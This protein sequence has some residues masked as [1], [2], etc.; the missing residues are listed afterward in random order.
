MKVHEWSSSFYD[1]DEVEK[2]QLIINYIVEV[3]Q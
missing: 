1:I 2:C 3:E